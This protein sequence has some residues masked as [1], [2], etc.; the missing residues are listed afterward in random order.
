MKPM[1]NIN[2]TSKPNKNEPVNN[3][4]DDTDTNSWEPTTEQVSNKQKD[5]EAEFCSS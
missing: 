3:N 1:M 5:E 2:A 4:I